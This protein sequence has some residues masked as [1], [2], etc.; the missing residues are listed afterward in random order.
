M[1]RGY[2]LIESMF[3]IIILGILATLAWSS[4]R[5]TFPRYYTNQAAR[6]LKSDLM[7]LRKI[8]VESNRETRLRFLS[9]GGDCSDVFSGGGAWELSIGDK[10]LGS[11]K[12][13]LLPEDSFNDNVDDD[14]SQGIRKIE[15]NNNTSEKDVCLHEWNALIGPSA[16]GAN[17]QDAVVFSPRGW[18]RNPSTDFATNGFIEL[19]IYNQDAARAQKE[20][21]LVVQLS[22]SGMVRVYSYETDENQNGVGVNTS[23]SVQ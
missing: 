15:K 9:H 13:D 8:A 2:T 10:S 6:H 1:R 5:S 14:Q 17:N 11:K 7:T 21:K 16:N 4:M 18:V 19:A 12:W 22:S 20:H 23:S 3:V